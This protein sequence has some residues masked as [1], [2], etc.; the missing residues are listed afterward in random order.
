[1]TKYLDVVTP[2]SILFHCNTTL[3]LPPRPA[4]AEATEARGTTIAH[5]SSPEA[6]AA[7]CGPASVHTQSD[8]KDLFS[9]LSCHIIRNIRSTTNIDAATII[10]NRHNKLSRKM[11]YKKPRPYFDPSGRCN[12]QTSHTDTKACTSFRPMQ[13]TA[14]PHRYTCIHTLPGDDI[15][16]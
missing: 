15:Q 5:T 11:F 10:S 14:T 2:H 1:M 6:P 16:T 12:T 3:G 9:T 13:Y 7:P 4:S 8:A